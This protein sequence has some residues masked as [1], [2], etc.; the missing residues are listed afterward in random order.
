MTTLYVLPEPDHYCIADD[1]WSFTTELVA[2]EI[3]KAYQR[4]VESL[5]IDGGGYWNP[6]TDDGSPH[7]KSYHL[8]WIAGLEAAQQRLMQMHCNTKGSHNLYQHAALELA[9]LKGQS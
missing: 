4:G 2:A 6:L 7:T 5:V 1:T 3:A 9:K 8:G